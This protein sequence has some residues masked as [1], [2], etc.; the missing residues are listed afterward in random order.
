M[1]PKKLIP[2]ML[3]TIKKGRKVLVEGLDMNCNK[4][5]ESMIVIQNGIN[6][7]LMGKDNI[8]VKVDGC[9][10]DFY[11]DLPTTRRNLGLL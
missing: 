7:V 8:Q 1:K 2:G 11:I 9:N 6:T 3:G 5:Y 10:F 4:V